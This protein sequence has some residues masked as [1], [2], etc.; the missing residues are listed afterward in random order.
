MTRAHLR[1]HV[2]RPA[3]ETFVASQAHRFSGR[4]LDYGCGIYPHRVQ[5]YRSLV[6]GEYVPYDFGYQAPHGVFDAALCT[7]VL[8]YVTSPLV[9]LQHLASLARCLVLTYPTTW[10]EIEGTDRWR[11][12]GAG[13]ASLARD[14]GLVVLENRVLWRFD[15]EDFN[16]TGDYGMVAVRA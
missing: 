6:T 11:F 8:E 14:A 13:M 9:T 3:L 16:L 5:P 7:Q 1:E 15:F 2:A 12:T 4:T 10:P